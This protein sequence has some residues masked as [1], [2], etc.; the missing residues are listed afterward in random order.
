MSPLK[1]PPGKATLTPLPKVVF[2]FE[3]HLE[4]STMIAMD[5]SNTYK[6]DL[7][8]GLTAAISYDKDGKWHQE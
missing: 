5:Q 7:S 2:W 4:S 3:A 1:F 6:V 8:G